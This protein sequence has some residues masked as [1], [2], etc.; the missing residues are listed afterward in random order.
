MK[1]Y[2]NP[3]SFSDFFVYLRRFLWLIYAADIKKHEALCSSC[4]WEREKFRII[5]Q[6]S[7]IGSRYIAWADY[8]ILHYKVILTTSN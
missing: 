3:S 1:K 5:M 2:P 7:V 6:E 4:S 8:C